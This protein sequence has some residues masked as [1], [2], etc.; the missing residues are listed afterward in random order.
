[1][2]EWIINRY[3]DPHNTSWYS[4]CTGPVE[5]AISY[6]LS[7]VHKAF[8]GNVVAHINETVKNW[9]AKGRLGSKKAENT[10]SVF[11]NQ[12]LQYIQTPPETEFWRQLPS[13][14]SQTFF[15]LERPW[16]LKYGRKHRLDI[17]ID[18]NDDLSFLKRQIRIITNNLMVTLPSMII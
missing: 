6:L 11:H 12:A 3:G 8:D 4:S 9:W 7:W 13:C 14:Y 17:G 16:H 18:A 2:A 15:F 10:C 5:N 1:M